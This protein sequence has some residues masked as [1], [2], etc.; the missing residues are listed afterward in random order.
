MA[1]V[2][3]VPSTQTRLA[4]VLIAFAAATDL[5]MGQPIGSALRSCWLAMR[6][7]VALRLESEIQA[8]V[9]QLSLLHYLGCTANGQDLAA[10]F[11][12]DVTVMRGF[13]TH[14]MGALPAGLSVALPSAPLML[15]ENAA[16]EANRSSCEVAAHL[17]ATC[18][19]S[20]AVQSGLW[21]LFEHW[22]GT[23]LPEHR[24]GQAI[25]LSVRVVQVARDF[26]TFW[27]LVGL[28]GALQVLKGRSGHGLDPELV[29][30]LVTQVGSWVDELEGLTALRAEVLSAEPSP[31][32]LLNEDQLRFVL[33]S[34]A[35]FAVIKS[36][37]LRGHPRAVSEMARAT[38]AHLGWDHV[39]TTLV[40]RTGLLHDLGCA[41]LSAGLLGQ[42]SALTEIQWEQVHLHP[43]HTERIL[44]NS[45]ALNTIGELAAQHHERLD[46]SGYHRGWTATLLSP[47]ARVLAVA[48]AYCA[49]SQPRAHRT[50]LA[51]PEI[52]RILVNACKAGQL[53]VEAVNAVLRTAGDESHVRI[54]SPSGLSPRELEVLRLL[55]QGHSNRGI[56]ELLGLRPKTV[57]HHV[58][59]VYEKL[60]VNSRAGATLL[61]MQNQWL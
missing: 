7:A 60:E 16:L 58:Q 47:Q 50:A 6:F 27:R 14:H 18:G 15:D 22:D 20:S 30:V 29:D 11:G 28:D 25:A 38:C 9:Y 49:M 26:E 59:H 32:V 42:S 5:G 41:G 53:E 33:E 54:Q 10:H 56:A 51:A 31:P 17:A 4:D 52:K 40:E 8:Q 61:A 21:Q 2:S 1:H 57:G 3:V 43:Y 44:K 46:G 23:G 45:N 37:W 48:D 24:R 34:L 13:L 55:A 36:P 39:T 12:S 19:L 35:D